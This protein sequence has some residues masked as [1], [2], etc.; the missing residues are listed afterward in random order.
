M[1]ETPQ[2]T[3]FDDEIARQMGLKCMDCNSKHVVYAITNPYPPAFPAGAYCFK[4]L[5]VC[6][7]KSRILPFPLPEHLL[8]AL[9]HDLRRLAT[10]KWY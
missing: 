1:Q 3:V 9:K 4:C 6:C 5:S 8:D 7:V 10:K 2:P